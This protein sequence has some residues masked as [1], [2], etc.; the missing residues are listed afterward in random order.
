M[1][2]LPNLD[3]SVIECT[4]HNFEDDIMCMPTNA[5][6]ALH[7]E[8]KKL[9]ALLTRYCQ[10]C[11]IIGYNSSR[12]D[13]AL[14]RKELLL[15]NGFNQ[16]NQNFVIKKNNSYMCISTSRLK[17]L[18]ASNYLAAGTSYDA[19][20][21]SFDTDVRKSFFPYEWLDDFLKLENTSL[22]PYDSFYSTLK[23]TNTLEAEY[24]TYHSLLVKH[25]NNTQ[26]TLKTM[27]LNSIPKTG[28]Q[29]YADLQQMWI[30]NNWKTVRDFLEM[31]NN[32]DVGPFIDALLKMLDIYIDK[33]INLFKD[34]VTV[35]SAAR[36]LVFSSIDKDVKFALCDESQKDIHTMF[37][38]NI[39]G[40][41]SIVMTRHQERDVTKIRG[42]KP[43]KKIVGYDA[44]R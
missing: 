39:C 21:K 4:I 7:E 17:F 22:P 16:K 44:N 35:P 15:Q 3:V 11:P 10:Q 37:K 19:F 36:S 6:K 24:N 20:L 26:A 38:R 5:K 32:A 12:Y 14:I 1:N 43:T 33:K 13:I 18:D 30:E 42:N 23:K 9:I 31:Y 29:N 34:C 25:N 8:V 27:N 2:T 28:P 41:P 40:G